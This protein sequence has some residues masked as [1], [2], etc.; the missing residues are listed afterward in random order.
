MPSLI[1]Q[2]TRA[3]RLLRAVVAAGLLATGLLWLADRLWPLPMPADDLARV[4][5]AEDGTPLWRFADADGV[6]RYPVSPEEVSPLYLEALLTY[7]DRWFYNHPG[8]NPLALARAAWLNLR[9]GRVVSGGSTLSMQVARLLDPHDRTLTGKSRQLWR[10]LQLEWHLS[11]AEILQ[12]YLNRAPFGG[13]LQGVAAAS[14]A[15]LGKSPKHLTPAEAALLA[16]LPQAP[17]RLRPDRHPQ[18]AQQARDKVLQRLADY[19]VWPDQRVREAREEPLLL[20]PR[21]EP[22]LAPLLARRLNTKNSPPLI[23]TTVDAAL[24]RRLEDLLLGWRARLPERTSAAILVVEAQSMAVRAYLGSIELADARRFGHVDMVHALRSPGS[25]LKPFLYGMA[26]DDGLIHSESLLQDVPRR[27]GDY[28][29]GN[30]SMGFS[31]PVSASAAL[32]LSLN[33]PAV[34]LLE[35]YGPKR[36]AAQMRMGGVPLALPPLAEPNL[37]LILGGAGSRLE[38]LVGG[39]AALARS[40][41]SA[42][43]RL[44]PQEPLL[45]RRLVSPGAAWII[46]RILS[47]QT[48]PDRDP[49]AELVQ[50][51]LLAWK[52]GTSYGFRDAWSIGVGPRYLIGVWIGR[53]DGTPVPG[54]FGLASAAPLMLQVHDLL[55]NRDSQRGIQPP[56][57][58]VPASVG[59]AA[60]C[61]PLGQPMNRQDANCRRQRFAWTLDGTT[62]PTLQAADQ[63]LGLGLRD[64]VWVNPQGLRVDASCSGAT[65]RA[66]ALWPAPLEPWL[67]RVERR[68]ARLP[69]VDPNCPPQVPASAPPLSIVGVRAGDNLRRPATSREP[70]QLQV[71]ALGGGGQ[72][73]WFVNGQPMGETRG[74]DSLQLRFEQRGRIELSALDES[75]ETARVEFQVSE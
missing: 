29:P 7:E 19:Q 68:A 72:R 25:T 5:L 22:A 35:A 12:L 30:F 47:G 73:W 37:S 51:P 32:A 40:G 17:S 34:Q 66:I 16:V 28:R 23:R 3:G 6:W 42:R 38:D 49:H 67:P 24:Q 21:Q 57:E 39:Y 1:R 18:R 26:L 70:L 52:T 53:P 65:A 4:V 61:W 48:R 43:I 13:T 50:R 58:Q 45:E 59:V 10:T 69:A 14:W 63:P 11:K 31:G 64:S 41:H 33:L 36:F 71:S 27:Y 20:A 56:V 75:G 74:Q 60:I 8:V 9:G 46:R 44:Q 54:Q 2:S 55:S 62:P 15:Y